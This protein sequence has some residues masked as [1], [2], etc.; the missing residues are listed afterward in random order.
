M[1][2]SKLKKF[3]TLISN[4]KFSAPEQQQKSGAKKN[5]R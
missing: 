3:M 4:R 2:T 1:E 5:N